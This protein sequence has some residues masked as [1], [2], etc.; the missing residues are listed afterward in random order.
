MVQPAEGLL[1]RSEAEEEL[2][3][4][5]LLRNS[6]MTLQGEECL[7]AFLNTTTTSL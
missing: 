2:H 4:V 5:H 1:E 6:V 3:D 7:L